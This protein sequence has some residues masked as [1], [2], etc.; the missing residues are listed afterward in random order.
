MAAHETK[1][2]LA[3]KLRLEIAIDILVAN[4]TDA[5]EHQR[6]VEGFFNLV[7]ARYPQARLSLTHSRPPSSGSR[8]RRA[9]GR[10]VTGAVV[11]YGEV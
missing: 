5:A 2:T 7:R 4:H 1:A 8:P 10:R 6:R 11:D 9:R 3:M